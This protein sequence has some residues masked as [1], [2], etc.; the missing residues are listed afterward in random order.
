MKAIIANLIVGSITYLASSGVPVLADTLSPDRERP[1]IPAIL[2]AKALEYRDIFV[3]S[4]VTF[5]TEPFKYSI[6][7]ENKEYI[8]NVLQQDFWQF[9]S[10]VFPKNAKLT[11][12][13]EILFEKAP[14]LLENERE[15]LIFGKHE[16][17]W[18]TENKQKYWGLTSVRTWGGDKA[19]NL[20]IEQLNYLKDAPVLAPGTSALTISGGSKKDLVKHQNHLLGE[21]TDFQGGIAF[22]QS[23]ADEVTLGLGFVYEDFLLG[24]SQLTYQPEKL[25]V[26]TT[27]SLLQGQEGIEFHSHLQL[28]PAKEIVLNLYADEKEQKFD[29]NWGLI[30]GLKLTADGS[31]ETE[32]L[33]AGAEVT[34]KNDFFSF[35]AKAQLDNE[36]KVQWQINSQLGNFKLKYTTNAVKTKT[37]VKYDF[38]SFQESGFQLAV[39]FKSHTRQRRKKEESLAVWGIDIYSPEKIGKDNPRWEFSLG[40]G[41]GLEGSGAIASM[42]AAISSSLSL[43]LSYEE[44]S[45]T[46]DETKVKLQLRSH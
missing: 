36:N 46:S 20:S 35:L 21:V 13:K 31:S 40:Y 34:F 9:K 41:S 29:F 39:F 14:Y 2:S 32:S 5:E 42:G 28:Q 22:H 16:N 6:S 1:E 15:D 19:N 12:Q 44:V 11:E 17:F 26:R 45:L 27:V 4:P 33:R 8:K 3:L 7:L 24:F 25:P 23:I 43:K 10:N 37:E 30:S 18:Q 38:D